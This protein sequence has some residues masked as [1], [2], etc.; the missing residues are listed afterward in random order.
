VESRPQD[1]RGHQFVQ[2]S[3]VVLI[4]R[5]PELRVPVQGLALVPVLLRLL[6]RDNVPPVVRRVPDSAMFRAA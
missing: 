6:P 2:E 1:R 5:V 4:R 3:V